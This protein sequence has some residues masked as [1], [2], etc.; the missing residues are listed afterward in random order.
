MCK[1]GDVELEEALERGM[2]QVEVRSKVE[3]KPQK[4]SRSHN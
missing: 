1:S 4:N 2:G 3:S